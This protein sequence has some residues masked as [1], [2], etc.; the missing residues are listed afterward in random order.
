VSGPRDRTRDVARLRRG[1][2][3]LSVA[4][5]D[6]HAG[7]LADFLALLERWNARINLTGTRDRDELIDNHIVD[8]LALLPHLPDDARTL[9]DVGAG[10][11]LPSV[12]VAVMRP[13][14]EVTALEPVH[15]KHAFL[16]TARRELGLARYRP[17]AE[18]LE[19]HLA[20]PEVAP[21]D[22]AVSRA[23]FA[24]EEWLARGAAAVRPGGIVL[25][26]EGAREAA[27]PAGARRLPYELGGRTRA[28]VRWTAEG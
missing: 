17:L 19:E 12:V 5:S 14:L 23:T 13:A 9:L 21:Y 26:M 18:R 20:R 24:L 8:S 3:A 25:G 27:L 16:A 7:Q 6:E 10:G 15:K 11:G 2:A 22:V 4:L 1:A 28:V